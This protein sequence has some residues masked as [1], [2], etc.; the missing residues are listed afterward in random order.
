MNPLFAVVHDNIS[1]R[2]RDEIVSFVATLT[3]T[4]ELQ[5][6]FVAYNRHYVFKYILLLTCIDDF[7][8]EKCKRGR[9]IKEHSVFKL[10]QHFAV[11]NCTLGLRPVEDLFMHKR[12][13]VL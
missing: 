1:D 8:A 3:H 6:R 12:P 9:L 10:S 11:W 7:V 2:E 5:S 4:F 13:S